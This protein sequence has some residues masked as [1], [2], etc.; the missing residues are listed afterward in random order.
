MNS[1][2][3]QGRYEVIQQIAHDAYLARDARVANQKVVIKMLPE[4]S[5][6]SEQFDEKFRASSEALAR[7]SHPGIV[8]IIDFGFTD[9]NRFFCVSPFIAGEDLGR[10][11][12]A[13]ALPR[14]RLAKLVLQIGSALSACHDHGIC[15]ADLKPD[16]VIIRDL[17]NGQ[18]LAVVVDFGIAGVVPPDV[19]GTMYY[20]APELR[21]DENAEPTPA[22]DIFS[23]G[24][25]VL[26][27]LTGRLH[28]DFLETV[29]YSGEIKGLD[30]LSEPVRDVLSRALNRVPSLRYQRADEFAQRLASAL[31]PGPSSAPV[32]PLTVFLCHS[33]SDKPAVRR[34][35][36]R[37]LA[38]GFSPWLDECNLLPGQ[39]WAHEIAKAVRKSDVVLACLSQASTT[40]TGFVNKELKL[41]LEFADEQPEDTIFLIPIRLDECQVP[42]RLQ[43]WHW[44]D[45]FQTDGYEKLLKAL[46]Y[47]ASAK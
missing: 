28:S 26:E 35:N 25:M 40:K 13:V 36:E 24:V 44:V 43:H 33:S 42:T 31:V 10:L 30:R 34:L 15:H 23:F 5:G 11:I 14:G 21:I 32:Q 6:D 7:L 37:L 46:L 27:A 45:L 1:T 22:S 4:H 3:Q 12:R 9:D 16:N 29:L 18:E 38:D 47:R 39:D 20:I 19:V 17:G 2:L 8:G 41:A